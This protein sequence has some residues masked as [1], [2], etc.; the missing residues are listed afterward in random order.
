MPQRA[1][2]LLHELFS[3]ELLGEHVLPVIEDAKARLLKP[4][5]KVL[6]CSASIMIA[7]P[8]SEQPDESAGRTGTASSASQEERRM[9]LLPT[10]G[11]K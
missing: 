9:A 8:P 3:S 10:A 2:V 5:G 4:G 6:P 7:F 11:V 1:D